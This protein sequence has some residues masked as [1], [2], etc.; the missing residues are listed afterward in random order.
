MAVRVEAT[1]YVVPDD[2]QMI[3]AS[4]AIVVGT[5]IDIYSRRATDDTIETVSRIAI[6]QAIRG[7]QGESTV[8]VVQWGGVLGNE[9]MFQSDAPSF[10]RGERVL[11]FLN[12]NLDHQWTTF[13]L[14]LGAFRFEV[15]NDGATVVRRAAEIFGWDE[16]GHEY[17]DRPRHADRFVEYVAAQARGESCIGDYHVPESIASAIPDSD[18]PVALEAFTGAS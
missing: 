14:A 1:S 18:G 12:R 15:T 6:E 11:L 17:V 8:D 5:V 2:R 13:S 10:R 7:F 4:E 3:A 16:S 9:Y